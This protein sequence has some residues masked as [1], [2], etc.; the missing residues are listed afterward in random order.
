MKT[1]STRGP[2]AQALKDNVVINTSEMVPSEALPVANKMARQVIGPEQIAKLVAILNGYKAGKLSLERRII[3]NELWFKGQHW[4]II[5]KSNAN[6]SDPEPASAWLF[7]MIA[8]KHADAMD[9]YPAPTILPRAKDDV[10]AAETLTQVV[11]VVRDQC[12]YEQTYSDIWWYKL[13]SGTGVT[14]VFWSPDKNNGLG[15]IDIR[16]ADLLNLFWAPGVS[17]IQKSPYFF[18]VELVDNEML[19]EQFPQ[20]K[21]HTGSGLLE[22]AKYAYEDNVDTSEK[23]LVVDC[24]Y[25]RRVGS[26]TV[27]HYVKFCNDVILYASENTTEYAERGF[28]DHGKYPFVFDVMFPE[29]GSPAGFGY[30]DIGKSPQVYIDKL[31]QSILKHAVMSARQRYWARQDAVINEAEF[32]DFTKDFVHYTGSGDPD[33]MFKPMKVP[34][35]SPMAVNVRTM[36]VDELK[37]T[38]GNRDFSQGSTA[39]G[40]TAA[41]AIAALQEAGSKL[42]RDMIKSSY[43]ADSAVTFFCI[44]LMRQFYDETRYFRITGPTGASEFVEF[45]NAMIAPV[46]Q[47][48]DFGMEMGERMPIFDIKVSSQKSSP[49]STVAQ[50]ERAKEFYGM[51]FF[52]PDLADQSLAALDMMQF[53]GIEKV[54]ENISKNRTLQQQVQQLAQLS[55]VM[56]QKIDSM[57]G[58]QYTEQVA[59]VIQMQAQGTPDSPTGG[60]T[61]TNA[62]GDSFTKARKGTEGAARASAA[63]KSTPRV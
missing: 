61:V 45:S 25:K 36:K 35:L 46:Q 56:A 52:R 11:P 4:E 8:N 57:A 26:R 32:A 47:G 21:G 40:V 59:Q 28:Y 2:A 23:S 14:G 54:R 24:Y 27:L 9:N 42:S 5:R 12:E 1:M 38:T 29:E 13:K 16:K 62:L 51:G 31:D 48:T 17:H 60:E 41:S 18:S 20:M 19:T 7:N 34:E 22:V 63:S 43:R 33:E 6:P 15:D 50:N 53:E 39:S 55:L 44:E 30:I 3:E 10:K 58:T 49:F 37:E